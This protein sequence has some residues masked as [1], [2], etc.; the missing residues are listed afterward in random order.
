MGGCTGVTV[1]GTGSVSSSMALTGV[2]SIGVAWIS[3]AMIVVTV[4]IVTH[5]GSMLVTWFPLVLCLLPERAQK[6][7]L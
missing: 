7:L 4:P 2:G 1:T 5:I 6:H 3:V